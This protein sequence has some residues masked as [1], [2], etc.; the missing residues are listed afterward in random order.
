MGVMFPF[1]LSEGVNKGRIT[2]E[3]AVAV[4]SYNT[5]N[6]YGFT[7]RKGIIAVGADAD[8]NVVDLG[9]TKTVTPQL[10]N[11]GADWTAY[12]GMDMTGWPVLTMVR[13]NIVAEDGKL[14][15]KPGTGRFIRARI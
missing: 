5:A 9:L 6:W 7:P 2:L 13:G 8:I 11:A 12:D 14:V 15:G 4:T 3:Q 10:L 1:M